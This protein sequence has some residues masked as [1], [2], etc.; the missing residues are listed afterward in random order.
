MFIKLRMDVVMY[1][2]R[3]AIFLSFVCLISLF[4]QTTYYVSSSQGNDSNNGTS[5]NSPWKTISKLNSRSLNPGD[6]ILFKKGDIWTEN[7]VIKNSG[8]SG[9]RIYYGGYSEGAKPII[10]LREEVPGWTN[11]A[12]WIEYSPNIWRMNITP[13]IRL[14]VGISR[15]WLDGLETSIA[16][17]ITSESN[18]D[19]TYGICSD[20][21]FWS[22]AENGA[23]YVYA[24]SN[25]AI[26]YSSIKYSGKINLDGSIVYDAIKLQNANFIVIDGL[27]IQGGM[28][29]AIR[30]DGS[31]NVIIENSSVGKYCR[32]A[33]IA[34]FN[35]SDFA[36]I[37][38]NNINSDF[39]VEQYLQYSA[40]SGIQY[41]IVAA[42][43]CTYWNIYNNYIKWWAMG[44]FYFRTSNIG[45][46]KYHKFYNNVVTNPLPA[47][48]GKCGQITSGVSGDAS[49]YIEIYNNYFTESPMG[50][51]V[52]ASDNKFYFNVFND[53]RG[54]TSTYSISGFA[55]SILKAD[56][57]NMPQNNF[58]FN[59]TMYNFNKWAHDWTGDQTYILNN[60]Y[61]NCGNTTSENVGVI[62]SQYSNIIFENNLFYRTNKGINDKMISLEN[63]GGLTVTE[64][65][66]LNGSYNKK[67]SGNLQHLGSVDS[68]MD[69]SDFSLPK[70]SLG[71]T[72]GTDISTLVPEGFKD[73]NG[74][75]VNRTKPDIGAVQYVTG[76]QIPPTLVS[77]ALLDSTKLL[78]TFSEPLSSSGI[79]SLSNYSISD[80]ILIYAAE[81]NTNETKITLTTSPHTFGQNYSCSVYNLQDQAGNFLSTTS[82]SITYFSIFDRPSAGYI[83]KLTIIKVAASNIDEPPYKTIDGI[84]YSNGG[85]ANSRWKASPIPQWLVY[86]LGTVKQISI[87]RISFYGFQ[88]GRIYNYNISVSKDSVNWVDIVKNAAS[89]NQEW[90]V[91]I[92]N[93][94]E[95]KFLKLEVTGNNQN[96][97]ATVW[98]TEIWG[99]SSLQAPLQIKPKVF[100]QGA[101]ENDQMRTN[102]HGSNLIPLS[103]PYISAPW[104]Y[105]G[106]ETVLSIPTAVVDWILIELRSTIS[107]TI[108][109]RAAFIKHDGTI[110]DLDGQSPVNFYGISSGDYYTII[111]HRNHLS[112]M[113]ADKVAL[114]ESPTL[115][116]FTVSPSR[117]YG[118]DQATLG[119]GKY[120][121]YSGDGDANGTINVLDYGTVGAKLFQT[122][123]FLSDLDLNASVNV[124]DY[125]KANQNLL[126]VSNVP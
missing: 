17:G 77:A 7:L 62:F 115:Y 28:Y 10:S 11:A 8:T 104:Y 125:G 80:G 102:L 121:M 75:I 126:K 114:S 12:N 78:L 79:A 25:P 122:G 23:L 40:S 86:D 59:N 61:V 68:L 24:T 29:C 97:W 19:G 90:T 18:G 56:A 51:Q 93:P 108:A 81:L 1:R 120:G 71:L 48:H 89:S 101:Y 73:R 27:D 103:Q 47:T 30:L 52:N 83:N 70:N 106:Y 16:G 69:A 74:T 33:G 66:A 96:D 95:A 46:S 117:A 9:Q 112:I 13:G 54:G 58:V 4:P 100:L 110:V 41:G 118:N 43:G 85:D 99:S 42:D 39:G 34:G 14:E 107:S 109:K 98:E 91:N 57:A 35:G 63:V 50:I 72:A 84:Y 55:F 88:E 111:R 65:N 76:D 116:D 64:W 53:I 44:G 49:T 45:V 37:R 92:F 26:F 2:M 123:Y 31:N 6:Q 20:H 105:N 21:K 5:E 124:L 38:N 87:T 3:I 94:V 32:F 67:I 113:S 36:I 119:N 82:N 22:S 15:I 60:L